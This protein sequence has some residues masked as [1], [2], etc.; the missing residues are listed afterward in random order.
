[1]TEAKGGSTSQGSPRID[2]K[3]QKP[4]EARKDLPLPVSER[5]WFY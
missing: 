4:V 2:S 1:M 3:P 5:D